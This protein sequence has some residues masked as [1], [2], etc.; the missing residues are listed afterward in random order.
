MPKNRILEIK[1]ALILGATSD[2]AVA[3]A[4]ELAGMGIKLLL[5]ARNM[6]D[7]GKVANY[8]NN[9][10]VTELTLLEFDALKFE[11]HAVFIQ[12]LPYLPDVTICAFGYLGNQQK[13]END[14][15]EQKLIYNT[16]FTG[17]VSVL[18]E[19][20]KLY[21]Q[22]GKGVIVGVSSVAG[23]RVRQ[24]NKYYGESKAAFSSYLLGLQSQ[25]P[26]GITTII[27]KPGLVATK[28]TRH[29]KLPAYITAKPQQV[30]RAIVKAIDRN[31]K[32]IYVLSVW[33]VIM[34]AIKLIP[35]S[36]FKFLNL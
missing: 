27:V 6:E 12:N 7:L 2:I 9:Y 26:I 23:D 13:A 20:V 36:M 30:A 32:E 28:M 16:N 35:E 33:R 18:N 10:S 14:K 25:L 24:S 21:K 3:L 19:I 5:A 11:E 22:A 15:D 31:T 1:T 17:A 8:I 34:F 29:L 4:K